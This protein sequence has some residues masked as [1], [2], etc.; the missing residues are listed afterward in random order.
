MN[1]KST[2]TFAKVDTLQKLLF[3]GYLRIHI[4]NDLSN[5]ATKILTM[6]VINLS[7]TFYT[8]SLNT[9]WNNSKAQLKETKGDD[10][11]QNCHEST[12][13]YHTTDL[14]TDEMIVNGEF[15][16]ACE[17]LKILLD[18]MNNQEYYA[19]YHYF[20]AVILHTWNGNTLRD[21]TISC[22]VINEYQKALELEPT[23]YAIRSH[24]GEHLE[25]MGKY[26]Q[27]LAVNNGIL[28]IH[29]NDTDTIFRIGCCYKALKNDPDA[30][31]YF[32]QA[33]TNDPE[34]VDHIMETAHC[35]RR[36]RD[37]TNANKCYVKAIEK[38]D[39]KSWQP[40]AFYAQFLEQQMRD[41]QKAETYY[42]KALEMEPGTS[43]YIDYGNML[44]NKVEDHKRALDVYS[45]L[46]E[47]KPN[48]SEY[49]LQCAHCYELLGDVENAEECYLKA[50]EMT[51]GKRMK[52]ICWYADWLRDIKKDYEKAKE[53]YFKVID[54]KPSYCSAYYGLAKMYRDCLKDYNE[55]K[56]WYLKSLEI[57][58][59]NYNALYGY[60]LYLMGEY[61]KAMEF[62]NIDLKLQTDNK[63]AYFYKGLVHRVFGDHEKAENA[64][65]QSLGLLENHQFALKALARMKRVQQLNLDYWTKFE[66]MVATKMEFLDDTKC[67]II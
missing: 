8:V 46:C 65:W 2:S 37:Y 10:W 44:K 63:W 24:Y 18:D 57:D 4:L 50:I 42:L 6:D 27:S 14:L 25:E 15:F 62:I 3:D 45:K 9:L 12:I 66:E 32:E 20:F 55:S 29:P 7:N 64:L 1:D 41:Y 60:L 52:P 31:K 16:I 49:I 26:E 43:V 54:I 5:D 56:K 11:M 47:L 61:E 58:D 53:Y 38:D 19:K 40:C 39:A 48:K 34:N 23:N 30:L 28:E 13:C 22:Q 33:M 36:L 51:D 59:N 35:H 67:R 21:E 17:L